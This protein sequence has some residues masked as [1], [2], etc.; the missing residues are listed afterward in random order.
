MNFI[1][2]LTKYKKR[3]IRITPD[4]TFRYE[5]INL[6]QYKP[7]EILSNNEFFENYEDELKRKN[8]K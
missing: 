8:K 5:S 3:G 4:K 2:N 6:F 7:N 1:K